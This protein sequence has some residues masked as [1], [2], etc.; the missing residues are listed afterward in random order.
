LGNRRER[1]AL[2]LLHLFARLPFCA[3]LFGV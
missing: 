2:P 1:C 3:H